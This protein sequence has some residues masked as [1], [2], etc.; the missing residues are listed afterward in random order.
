M[1]GE[2]AWPPVH[3]NVGSRAGGTTVGSASFFRYILRLSEMGLPLGAHERD[4]LDMLAAIPHAF[5]DDDVL[6]GKGWRIVPAA[7]LD[8]WPVLESSPQRLRDALETARRV[9]W[10]HAAPVGISAREIVGIEEELDKV[11]IV[12]QQ[13]EAAGV[14]VNISYVS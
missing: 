1:H 13:A 10:E 8:D 7:S 6:S 12:L 11:L 9:L 5:F 4:A 14:S 2:S 3:V